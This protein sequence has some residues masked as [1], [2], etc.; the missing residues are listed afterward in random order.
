MAENKVYNNLIIGKVTPGGNSLN[1]LIKGRQVRVQ[2]KNET[3]LDCLQE[4]D[5]ESKYVG[6]LK[7]KGLKE[8]LSHW[9]CSK[10]AQQAKLTSDKADFQRSKFVRNKERHCIMTKDSIVLEDTTILNV[11]IPNNRVSKHLRQKLIG[12]HGEIVG[13]YYS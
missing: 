10:K 12:L 4:I 6:R 8:N 3:T 1:T 5:F 13:D 7:N 11:C 2:S 9:Y